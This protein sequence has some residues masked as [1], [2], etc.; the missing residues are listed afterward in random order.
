MC[1]NFAARGRIL[2]V[3]VEV[4][5]KYSKGK[6]RVTETFDSENFHN[7][8]HALPAKTYEKINKIAIPEFFKIAF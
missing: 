6:N 4:V 5:T 2:W 1:V 7:I 8:F 3:Y